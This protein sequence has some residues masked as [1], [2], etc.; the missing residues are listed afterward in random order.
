MTIT[1]AQLR[2]NFPEFSSNTRFPTGQ[3]QFW[4]DFAY[5]MLS[6]TRWGNQL[7]IA[8][9]L[10]ASHNVVLERRALDESNV[11]NSF[12]EGA[13]GLSTGV[14][15]SKSVDKNSV[16]YSVDTSSI[17]GAGDLNLTIYGTRL[18]RLIKLFGMGP[19]YVGGANVQPW[20]NSGAWAGPPF[21]PGFYG[22]T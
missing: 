17:P 14:I 4:L 9:Q 16:S 20:W 11:Q 19:V 18:A 21:W 12:G 1:V 13:P 15:S 5:A 7:D 8:A 2:T 3:I 22:S 6:T 10:Y